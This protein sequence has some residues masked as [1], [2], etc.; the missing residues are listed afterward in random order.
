MKI[1]FFLLHIKLIYKLY[2][3][4]HINYYPLDNYKHMA[5]YLLIITRYI[6]LPIYLI[7]YVFLHIKYIY[8]FYMFYLL[9]YLY[10]K[11]F[12]CFSLAIFNICRYTTS[13]F[14][15]SF[16]FSKRMTSFS[17]RKNGKSLIFK[18]GLEKKLLFFKSL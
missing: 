13:L 5:N 15:K 7:L 17:R 16:S 1:L 11:F 18:H 10:K 6:Y 12:V 4:N 8:H 2:Q 3:S 9:L 14:Y